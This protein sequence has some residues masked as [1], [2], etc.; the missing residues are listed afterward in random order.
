VHKELVA[1]QRIPD[2]DPDAAKFWQARYDDINAF[3]RHLTRNG[4]A[5]V[6]F[7]LHVS[8]EEQQKRFLERIN[9]PAKHW[10][11]A[12]SDVREREFWDDYMRA[13]ED[14]LEHTSTAHAPW[15]VIPADNKWFTRL[16]VAAIIYDALE[17]LDLQYPS[18][19]PEKKAELQQVRKLLIA[20]KE[21]EE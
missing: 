19:T 5:I 17:R 8:P 13:Y 12:A 18:L 2:A 16:A 1:S 4:T 15:Y 14:M 3:E 10:K 9:N 20:E 7:F 6:K 11:F 21:K